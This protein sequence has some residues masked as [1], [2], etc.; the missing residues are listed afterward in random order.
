MT[1]PASPVVLISAAIVFVAIGKATCMTGQS[2][3]VDGGVSA[4]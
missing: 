4:D 1:T 2:I 3:S